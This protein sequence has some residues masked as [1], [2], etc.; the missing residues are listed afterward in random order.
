[1][2][3]ACD[4]FVLMFEEEHQHL[5]SS[6]SKTVSDVRGKKWEERGREEGG[7]QEGQRKEEG[8]DR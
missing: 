1:M 4:V 7:S 6:F 8:A 2:Y 5:L 3:S